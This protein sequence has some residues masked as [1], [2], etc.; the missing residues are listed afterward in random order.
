ML[1]SRGSR[2]AALAFC[3]IMLVGAASCAEPAATE[4]S[5]VNSVRLYGTDGNM[6]NSFGAEFEGQTTLLTGM[7]GTSP[8]TPLPD[9]FISRLRAVDRQL[10]GFLYAGEAYDAV[11]I[12]AL[13]TQ[14]AG[15]T[16]PTDIAAQINGVTT[17]G[18]QCDVV[19]V[20]LELAR[21]GTDIA[22]RGV[23][24][25]R[26]G[27]TDAGEPSTAS[28]ATLHFDGDG[29]INDGKTEFV[30]AGDES[31]TTTAAP[32][33]AEPET[34][35]TRAEAPLKLGGLLPR[36]GDLAL[37]YPPLAAGAA[38]AVRE[39]NEA[40]GVLGEP[41][42]WFDGDDGTNPDV[43]R[44]TVA[45]H[46]D[47][48]VHVI[49]GAGASGISREVLPDVAAAGLILF[50]PSNTDA[51]LSEVDDQG[52]YFR[53]APSDL[54]QGRA[55][56]DVILRDG[57][58]RI[59]LVARRDSYGEGLQENVR[60]EL[61][62]AGVG[63]DRL[64]LLSYEPPAGADAPPVNFDSEAQEIKAFGADAILIIGFAE[65]AEV[66]KSLAAAGLPIAE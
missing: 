19:A 50:S 56:A 41:V 25:K 61:D 36:T 62:R 42:E 35:V 21:D 54:L 40:G 12:S 44:R 65:S 27:F 20:C 16:D 55:L 60:A 49:I 38:L 5:Q 59:A 45:R 26:G 11:V 28:Y 3:A 31:T 37:A 34:F 2:T 6:S 13:A 32:P 58:Q 17:G 9:D 66:I 64:K 14:L 15:S 1:V 51:G 39:V 30:G 10:N 33:P 29:Q 22:Y 24:L 23:S 48:G 52:L 47:E 53:T 8:L 46:V 4:E 63:P 7:K 57:S 18:E 43:A